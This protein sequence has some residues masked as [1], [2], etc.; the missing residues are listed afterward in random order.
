MVALQPEVTDVPNDPNLVTAAVTYHPVIRFTTGDGRLVELRS[1]FGGTTHTYRL[2]EQV[3]VLYDPADPSRARLDTPLAT[4]LAPKLIL[5]IG[6]LLL[7][8]AAVVAALALR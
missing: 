4:T 5:V 8:A 6:V 2:G 7:V 1:G 3:P